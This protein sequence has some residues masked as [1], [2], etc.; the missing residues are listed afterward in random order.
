ME[1]GDVEG[2][3][4]AKGYLHDKKQWDMLCKAS[5]GVGDEVSSWV[6]ELRAIKRSEMV[7]ALEADARS[8]SRTS[9]ASMKFLIANVYD[10]PKGGKGR[11]RRN[12]D[13]RKARPETSEDDD[14]S[15]VTGLTK[16]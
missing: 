16:V 9:T 15:R 11:P 14:F 3:S 8:E 7:A 5:L 12:V 13:G 10:A 6:E 2:G 1:H 4:F